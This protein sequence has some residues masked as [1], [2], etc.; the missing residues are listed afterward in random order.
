MLLVTRVCLG[1]FVLIVTV[2][3]VFNGKVTLVNDFRIG[4]DS[5]RKRRHSKNVYSDWSEWSACSEKCITTRQR[6][7]DKIYLRIEYLFSLFSSCCYVMCRNCM[8]PKIC[9]TNIMTE[10]SRCFTTVGSVECP[11]LIVINS[12]YEQTPTTGLQRWPDNGDWNFT[13]GVTVQDTAAVSYFQSPRY[14]TKIMGGRESDRFRWP[15]QVAVLS[16]LKELICGGTL[17]TPGWV[18]TAAHCSRRKLYVRLMEHDLYADEGSEL[19]V[20][21]DRIIVHPRYNPY[22]VDNDVALLKLRTSDLEMNGGGHY[23]PPACLPVSDFRQRKRKPTKC[24]VIGWGKVR[25]RDPY[26]SQILQ[27][28]TVPI[29]RQRQCRAAYR[30]YMITDNM[31]CAGYKDGRSDTCSGDSG[32]PLLCRMH[33]RWTV[34]GVTSFGD[35]CGRR[36][37]YGIYASVANYVRWIVTATRAAD[38]G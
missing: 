14:S 35:G 4:S 38:S 11:V 32:G 21:V 18:L 34:V 28:A 36:G 6:L 9:G 2:F 31:F 27:E 15:W 24:V 7:V 30:R 16:G 10:S 29:V 13:C 33:G 23:L 3:K 37:K 8:R 5:Q 22:T 12:D 25:S 26:G 19:D 1:W 20:R 17:I